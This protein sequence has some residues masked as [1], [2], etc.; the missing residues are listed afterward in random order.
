MKYEE[1]IMYE[2]CRKKMTEI[3]PWVVLEPDLLQQTQ[4]E[5]VPTEGSV[6]TR[7]LSAILQVV[8]PRSI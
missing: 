5:V 7:L 4:P 8:N 2:E 6:I 1:W 3:N